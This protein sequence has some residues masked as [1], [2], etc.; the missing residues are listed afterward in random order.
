MHISNNPSETEKKKTSNH[1]KVISLFH[2]VKYIGHV[3]TVS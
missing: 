2:A 3:S 1:Q